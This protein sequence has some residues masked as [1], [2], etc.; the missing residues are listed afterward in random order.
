MVKLLLTFL[1]VLAGPAQAGEFWV[2]P[3]AGLPAGD[4]SEAQPW[5]SLQEVV[6]AGLIESRQWESYPYQDGLGLVAKNAGAPVKAGDTIWLRSGYHGEVL[7]ESYYNESPITIAAEPGQEPRLRNIQ[8]RAGANWVLRGLQVSP[9]YAQDYAPGTLI[10]LDHHSYRGPVYDVVVEDCVLQSVADIS[11]WSADDW[12]NLACN[13]FSVDGERM[14]IRR[15][16]V[17][18]VNF[19]ISVQARNSMVEHNQ[20]INFAGDG[21]RG[22][23]DHTTFQFNLI[24]NSYQVNDNHDDGFQSWSSGE[25]GVGTGEV[26][27]IVLRGNTFINYEDP[28]QPFRATLQGIGCFDGTFV[29]WVVENNV[30]ITDHY[31]GITLM[32]ARNCRIVNN[33][34]MDLNDTEPGP[35]WIYIAPHK[36]GTPVSGCLIRNNLT[37]GLSNDN[38]DEVTV[39]HNLII[40]NPS[41]LFVDPANGDL[42]LMA[43]CD[44]IDTGSPDLVPAVDIEGLARP[45]GEGFDL[46]AYEYSDPIVEEPDGGSDV[47][48][49]AGSDAGNDAGSDSDGGQDAG[50]DAGAE[51][52]ADLVD[53][54][55]ADGGPVG[56]C[57]CAAN[58]GG[59]DLVLWLILWVLFTV[60][61]ICHGRRAAAG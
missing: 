54:S 23:G 33:T 40:E 42:H 21:L 35:P 55:L 27:G 11:G 13:G 26:T 5:R 56:S 28:A 4:G 41:T 29:D 58:G 31:H 57:G 34:V 44:A 59:D 32:G 25:G 15:N 2:D 49:D 48:N 50:V 20:V 37:T 9:E 60:V 53:D 36:N 52:G 12:N 46:G 38:G 24:K 30:V 43:D 19:G 61:R 18:N 7:I 6:E 51:A 22:L 39:D 8:L 1:I 47:G 17:R 3:Q 10:D 16:L 14:T 45:Q